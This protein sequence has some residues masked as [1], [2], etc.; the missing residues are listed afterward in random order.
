MRILWQ[1]W[2]KEF[3]AAVEQYPEFARDMMVLLA[4]PE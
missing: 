2:P 1:E 3:G 4:S